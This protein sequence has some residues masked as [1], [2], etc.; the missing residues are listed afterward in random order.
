[1]AQPLLHQVVAL[2]R[3]YIAD[4]R[5]WAQGVEAVYKN[6]REAEPW[7]VLALRFCATGALTRAAFELTDDAT[8]ARQLCVKTCKA[9]RREP[10]AVRVIQA[11][12]DDDE[13]TSHGRILAIFDDFLNRR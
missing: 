3:S 11:I 10:D 12:N 5:H 13:D 4:P 8:K 1:M 9:L 7:A 2:A 6:G